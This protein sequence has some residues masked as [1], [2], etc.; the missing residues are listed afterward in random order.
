MKQAPAA[1]LRQPGLIS[2]DRYLCGAGAAAEPPHRRATGNYVAV[3]LVGAA[4]EGDSAE[5]AGR[6]S[7]GR[8]A[9]GTAHRRALTRPSTTQGVVTCVRC[10]APMVQHSEPSCDPNHIYLDKNPVCRKSGKRDFYVRYAR[11]QSAACIS[12]AST[13]RSSMPFLT[14]IAAA[15]PAAAPIPTQIGMTR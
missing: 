7:S 6:R 5:G 11:Y 4:R 8:F 15:T 13:S 9:P 2:A 3:A 1:A 12:F 10:A 14:A